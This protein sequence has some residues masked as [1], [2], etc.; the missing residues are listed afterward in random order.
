MRG[1]LARELFVDPARPGRPSRSLVDPTRLSYDGAA[2]PAG[3]AATV[4]SY[5]TTTAPAAAAP[6]DAPAAA[7]YPALL[8]ASAE[9]PEYREIL[10]VAYPDPIDAELALGLVQMRWDRVVAAP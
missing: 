1:V 4:R 6:A 7:S 5:A 8:E 10:A 2:Q 9:W 3:L